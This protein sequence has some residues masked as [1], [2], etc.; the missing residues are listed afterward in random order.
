MDASSFFHCL[1]RIEPSTT[2]V[3]IG[4]VIT[5]G[6]GIAALRVFRASIVAIVAGAVLAAAGVGARALVERAREDG[7][8]ADVGPPTTPSALRAEAAGPQ[9]VD[10]TWAAASDDV[11]VAGY[12]IYRDGGRLDTVD[13][14]TL[15]FTDSS[16][17]P[18][19]DYR[20][21]VDAF[22]AAGNHSDRSNAALVTTPVRT[23]TQPPSIPQGLRAEPSTP[24][25]VLLT[26]SP[27]EDNIGIAGYTIFRDETELAAVDGLATTYDDVTVAEGSTY[28]YAVE[29][30]DGAGNRSGRSPEVSV[31]TSSPTDV[32]P[33]IAPSGVAVSSTSDGWVV[34]WEPSTDDV[35]VAGY[36]VLRNG[37]QIGTVDG[38]TTS[39]TDTADLCEGRY[40]YQVV[41]FDEAQ[42][43][44][45]PGSAEP[46]SV[47]C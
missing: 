41:A 6:R 16:V 46:L 36:R 38:S 30:F 2:P 23:D 28:V 25:E 45:E 5:R 33:P 13:G 12:T 35:G 24:T 14:T 21:R 31:T 47:V 9:E 39:F 4:A 40:V 20:Y 17:R 10:L 43:A 26:W 27:S 32:T 3:D 8:L 11:A 1:R 18:D 37:E 29:A 22:D 42:N 44:S 19:T 34:R 15:G 7:P